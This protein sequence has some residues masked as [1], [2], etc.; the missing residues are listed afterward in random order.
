[1]METGDVEGRLCGELA[2]S[3]A[4]HVTLHGHKGEAFY[5][6]TT[7]D[8]EAATVALTKF[9]LLAP[10]PRADMP[11][12]IWYCEHALTMD[13][14]AMPE[15]L[16]GR[17]GKDDPRFAELLQAW[18]W[19][20]CDS[21]SPMSTRREPIDCLE[22]HR[23]VARALAETG[24]LEPVGAQ[25]RWTDKIGPAMVAA[26]F[27]NENF[28][29]VEEIEQRELEAASDEIVRTMPDLV[30]EIFRDHPHNLLGMWVVLG[31]LWRDGMWRLDAPSENEHDIDVPGGTVLA[32]RVLEKFRAK[33]GIAEERGT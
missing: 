16:A 27:W 19:V 31:K 24:Y 28:E 3:I 8:R 2:A 32:G 17:V 6:E 7:S 4:R 21:A 13:A 18:L 12:E 30:V 14:D 5:H 33:Y 25:Y 23:N 10:V 1:M 20:V 11:G 26:Y 29:S 15:Y 9:G 22:I